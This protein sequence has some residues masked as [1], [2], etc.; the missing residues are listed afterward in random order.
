MNFDKL[1]GSILDIHSHL[2]VSV[3]KAVNVLLTL[4]NLYIGFYIIE[5][6]QHGEDR[7][8]YGS[9]LLIR[10]SDS[11]QIKGL[12]APEL[13][14]CRQFYLA[15]PQILGSVTQKSI[16]SSSFPQMDDLQSLAILGSVTQKSLNN[17][18]HSETNHTTAILTNISYTQFT[19]LIKVEDPI[20]RR[21]YELLILQTQPSVRELKRQINTLTY[22]RLGLSSNYGQ[23][24]EKIKQNV[25]PATPTDLIKST[26]IFE[27][28]DL[29]Q[30][31]LAEENE[32][33][34][35]LINHLQ[36]FILE[37]GNGFCFEARQKRILIGDEYFFIDLVFYHRIL[38]CHIL[39]DLKT[40]KANHEHIGQLK[41][42][43]NYYKA[44]VQAIDDNPPV[45]ILLVTDQNKALVEY[46]M[47]DSDL[48][49][50]VS[51]YILQLPSKEK[52]ENFIT[53]ELNQYT[54]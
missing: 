47:A 29:P 48:D 16:N 15:Y 25:I 33:E 44:N 31:H 1:T 20:K 49:L 6:E 23:A 2:Q 22:E 37:L 17:S 3:K 52:L 21:F 45:G 10:L 8:A 38:K 18:D 53:K 36:D 24:L 50:F 28:L 39:I 35:A 42:Y 4:R 11:L 14:R 46:A 43:I 51:K 34:Q 13:S 12:T 41:T 27:F 54:K 19:E 32:L 30:I 26:Y 9:E 5:Y 40:E 7:A